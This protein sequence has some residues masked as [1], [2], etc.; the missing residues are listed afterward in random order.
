MLW[1]YGAAQDVWCHASRS[2]QKLSLEGDCFKSIWNQ[3]SERLP[4]HALEEAGM[5][6]RLIWSRRNEFVHGK[7]FRHPNAIIHKAYE[8]HRCFKATKTIVHA[9]TTSIS[10]LNAQ[11]WKK[12]PE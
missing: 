2:L 10:S 7:E 12:P 3:L 6:L 9:A 4:K 1:S 5:I 11:A 8:D